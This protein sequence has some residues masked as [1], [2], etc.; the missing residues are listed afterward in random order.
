M[1]KVHKLNNSEDYAV[2]CY[3]M[4][5]HVRSKGPQIFHKSMGHLQ[6]LG[7]TLLY[8]REKTAVIM[9]KIGGARE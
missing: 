8:V 7:A 5:H 6:I 3:V 2:L 4:L 1:E 9:P